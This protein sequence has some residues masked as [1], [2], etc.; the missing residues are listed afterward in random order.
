MKLELEIARRMAAA[1]KGGRRS[2]MERIAVISVALSM[3]VMLLSMAV[4][5]GFKEE[6]AQRMGAVASHV[7]VS[8]VRSVQAVDRAH[9]RATSHLDSLIAS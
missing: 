2:V 4:I 8:D 1:S 5:M 9:L 7:V 6:I 3:A